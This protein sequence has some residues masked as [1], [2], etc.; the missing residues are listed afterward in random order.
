MSF[1]FLSNST[2]RSLYLKWMNFANSMK[3]RAAIWNLALVSSRVDGWFGSCVAF[4][5]AWTLLSGFGRGCSSLC[6]R[7]YRERDG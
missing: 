1:T 5:L 4:S 6:C 3:R 2:F 7:G